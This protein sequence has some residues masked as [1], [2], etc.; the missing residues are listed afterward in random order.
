MI[1]YCLAGGQEEH[2]CLNTL[3]E[4]AQKAARSGY[5]RRPR[6]A[7][8]KSG[9]E[10]LLLCARKLSACTERI[11]HETSYNCRR[12]FCRRTASR[13]GQ[14]FQA[15]SS[16]ASG[17][18]REETVGRRSAKRECRSIITALGCSIDEDFNLENLKYHKVIILSDADR[19]ALISGDPHHLFFRYMRDL[20]AAGHLY[21]DNPVI[22]KTAKPGVYCYDDEELR[23]TTAALGG[24]H[25]VQ[26][27][28][29]LGEMNRN[30]FGLRR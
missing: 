23:K 2:R 19:T 5:A 27:Y 30:S 11:P 1:A 15:P 20:V 4:K 8:A 7:R 6:L 14:R 21:M 13:V 3:M 9:L 24:K 22:S 25:T 29:G 16:G 26:R 12:G 17:E 10:V 18:C 28:K